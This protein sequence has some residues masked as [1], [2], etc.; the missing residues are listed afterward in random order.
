M[1]LKRN[2]LTSK[3]YRW[4][5]DKEWFEMPINLCVYFWQLVF[6]WIMFIPSIILS[7]PYSIMTKMNNKKS[8]HHP[9]IGFLLWIFIFFIQTILIALGSFF[10]KYEKYSYL[11]EMGIMGFGIIFILISCFFAY[12]IEI[13]F[14]TSRYKPEQSNIIT[15]FIK[16]KYNKYCPKIDWK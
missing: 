12:H 5:Y 7:L 14:R 15:E 11:H 3:I 16:A 8:E 13:Y 1:E 6:M 9:G 2:S 10:F 4:F